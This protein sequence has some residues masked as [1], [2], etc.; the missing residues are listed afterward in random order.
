VHD[1]SVKTG[2]SESDI[3]VSI[4]RGVKKLA[5]LAAKSGRT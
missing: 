5:A 4:H 2:M 1:A 3:K